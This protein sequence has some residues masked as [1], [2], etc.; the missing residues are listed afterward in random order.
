MT[1]RCFIILSIRKHLSAIFA[2]SLHELTCHSK[3]QPLELVIKFSNLPEQ[4]WLRYL[5]CFHVSRQTLG[6]LLPSKRKGLL[7]KWMKGPSKCLLMS[8]TCNHQGLASRVW[9]V[10]EG[11]LQKGGT[12]ADLIACGPRSYFEL[13]DNLGP[14]TALYSQVPASSPNF[15]SC[16]LLGL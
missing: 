10:S 11:V 16:L 8:D 4:P 3:S 13:V 15:P 1:N 12:G 14:H 5:V 7:E 9:W 2:S 6:V